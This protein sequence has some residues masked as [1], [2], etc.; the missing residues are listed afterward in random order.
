MITIDLPRF[1]VTILYSRLSSCV[2]ASRLVNGTMPLSGHHRHR[3]TSVGK[4]CRMNVGRELLE[5]YSHL[6]LVAAAVHSL[7]TRAAPSG[8]GDGVRGGRQRRGKGQGKPRGRSRARRGK[9]SE[10]PS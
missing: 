10:M 1:R 2:I 6:H 5:A 9:V 4:N 7:A 3:L 8:G